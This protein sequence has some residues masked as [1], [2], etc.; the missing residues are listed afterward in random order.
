MSAYPASAGRVGA[1]LRQDFSAALRRIHVHRG[2]A[3]GSLIV[4]ALLGFEAFNFGTTE[5]ALT[6]LLGN[7]HFGAVSWATVLALA[8]CGI[9]FAGLVRLFTPSSEAQQPA[10]VW[11]LIGAWFLAA[12]MNATL[13]W[14]GVSLALLNHQSLG[15]ALVGAATL[16]KAAPIFVAVLVWIVRVLIIG[17]LSLSGRRIFSLDA[18]RAASRLRFAAADREAPS[19]GSARPM[20]SLRRTNIPAG[21]P[22]AAMPVSAAPRHG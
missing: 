15:G 9:D 5:F 7:L 4:A 12:T 3:I 21:Q 17:A 10:E 14:W 13:T 1:D 22:S 11:Y 20:G 18:P 19:Q 6:D 2:M 16:Q 8:F